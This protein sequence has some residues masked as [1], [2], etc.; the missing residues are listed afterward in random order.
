MDLTKMEIKMLLKYI[1]N[2]E[3]KVIADEWFCEELGYKGFCRKAIDKLQ[4]VDL[5][6]K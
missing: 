3:D 4:E 6:R 2:L 1:Y 5:C